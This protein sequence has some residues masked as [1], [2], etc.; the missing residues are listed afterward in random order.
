MDQITH[1]VK[2][3][4]SQLSQLVPQKFYIDI[5]HL[6]DTVFVAGSGRSGTTWLEEI[7]NFDNQYRIMFEPFHSKKVKLISHWKYFQY[8]RENN[9]DPEFVEPM[10]KILRGK[11]KNGWVDRHNKK[12]F[13]DKRIVKAVHANLFLNWLNKKFKDVPIILILRHPCAVVNSK[14]NIAEKWF[15]KPNLNLF[16]RQE[17]LLHDFLNPFIR[18]INQPTTVFEKFILMWCI[19][20]YVPLKQFQ[21]NE[22]LRDDFWPQRSD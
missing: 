17:E 16:L 18:E 22:I 13:A 4:I 21:Q 1:S 10:T 2:S 9:D 19:E 11:L 12:I 6:N 3:K 5:G 7:I 20:N 8:I 14:M 15:K